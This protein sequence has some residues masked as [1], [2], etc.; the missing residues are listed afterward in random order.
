MIDSFSLLV[1]QYLLKSSLPNEA[2]NIFDSCGND[3]YQALRQILLT[4]HPKIIRY[5]ID[6]CYAAP[7]QG[8]NDSASLYFCQVQWH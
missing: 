4:L 7:R 6:V 2:T 3:G 5:L 1:M 8:I